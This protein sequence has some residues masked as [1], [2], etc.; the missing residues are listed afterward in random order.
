MKFFTSIVTSCKDIAGKLRSIS[1]S[2]NGVETENRQMMQHFGFISVPKSGARVLFL[3]LGNVTVAV[4]S[5]EKDRPSL[6]EGE[7]ALYRSADHYIILKKDGSVAIKATAGVE[8]EGDLKVSG[9]VKDSV[10]SLVSLRNAYNK[11]THIGNLGEPTATPIP[12]DT[13]A[14]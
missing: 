10:G 2:A 6:S 3:Q 11:H 7:S 5:D 4:A 9:D 1:A 12:Q 14:L 13:G 8:I